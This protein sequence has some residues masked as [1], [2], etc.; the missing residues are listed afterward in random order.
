M[1]GFVHCRGFE[2]AE[3]LR[4]DGNMRAV[5]KKMIEHFD[6]TCPGVL[7]AMSSQSPF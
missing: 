4:E 1:R 7:L 2:L 6:F 5:K 3:V